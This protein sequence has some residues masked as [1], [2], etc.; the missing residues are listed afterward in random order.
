MLE[1]IEVHEV[2]QVEPE[3]MARKREQLPSPLAT[4]FDETPSGEAR[5]VTLKPKASVPVELAAELLLRLLKLYAKAKGFVA[6]KAKAT[7]TEAGE[8]ELYWHKKKARGKKPT[9]PILPKP[10]ESVAEKPK[11]ASKAPGPPT[12]PLPDDVD[13][14]FA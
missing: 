10:D 6:F 9:P 1:D 13:K 12:P 2:R 7:I 3:K 11:K 14:Q 8:V 5:A 4:A